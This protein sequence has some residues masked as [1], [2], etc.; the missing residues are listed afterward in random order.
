MSFSKYFLA[1]FLL[2]RELCSLSSQFW[3]LEANWYRITWLRAIECFRSRTVNC[4]FSIK[5]IASII[6]LYISI[7]KGLLGF[8]CF[9]LL[10]FDVPSQ[11][12][13]VL[14][15]LIF[16]VD[17]VL[18]LLSLLL[19]KLLFVTTISRHS[20]WLWIAETMADQRPYIICLPKN[21]FFIQF[22]MHIASRLFN[23]E[24]KRRLG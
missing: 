14:L 18:L 22:I 11:D 2:M 23:L 3:K 15:L 24:M 5:E 20:W 17:H 4:H 13:S 21:V 1:A 10:F 7:R 9:C 19:F 16:N 12:F 8:F 6:F